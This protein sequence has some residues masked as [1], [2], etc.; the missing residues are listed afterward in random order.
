MRY[1]PSAREDTIENKLWKNRDYMLL[2]GAQVVS[3][4]GSA[5]SSIVYPLL[6]LA[7]T[8]SPSAAGIASALRVAP[9]LVFCIPVGALIDRWDRK[10]VMIVCDIG[11]LIAVLCIPLAIW[12]DVLA[13]WQIYLVCLVEGSFFVFFNIAEVAALPRVVP[14]QQLPEATAQNQAAFNAAQVAGP[15]IGTMLF[16][17]LGRSAP[18][19]FDALSYLASAVSLALI[20]SPL[21]QDAPASAGK[22]GA[23]IAE[24]LHWLWSRPLIRTMAFLTGGINFIYAATPLIMI[25]IGKQ[26]GASDVDI[27]LMFSIGGIGGVL[28]SLVG[29]RIQRRFSFGQVIV[30]IVWAQA[31]LFPLYLLVPNV[32]LLGAVYA[33]IYMMSP[34]FNVVQFSYRVA[35]IPDALQGRVNSVFRLLAH[36]F[37]PL[38]AAACGVLLEHAGA[39]WTV[40]LFAAS[41]LMLAVLTTFSRDVRHAP[42][43][44]AERAL[45]SQ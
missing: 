8:N 17:T 15:S 26:L 28:G 35:L 41:Y 7:L 11:R 44:H 25:V 22:L 21:R 9:Y 20:R 37:N 29:G 12:L 1:R 2:W 5:A 34:V 40:V 39:L 19:V 27:G 3:T 36:G 24:G 43:L 32:F 10:R 23:Q 38:G 4:L 45:A 33:L 30:F 31:I 42:A 18:F 6:I 13:L 16:Q 14:L